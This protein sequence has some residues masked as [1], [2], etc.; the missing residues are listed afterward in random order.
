MKD[1]SWRKAVVRKSSTSVP[2]SEYPGV[3]LSQSLGFQHAE[4]REAVGERAA[5]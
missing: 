3:L 5:F 2:Q 4:F 1:R